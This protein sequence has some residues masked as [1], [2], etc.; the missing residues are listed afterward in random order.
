MWILFQTALLYITRTEMEISQFYS[1]TCTVIKIVAACSNV[2]EE[3]KYQ[4]FILAQDWMETT[5]WQFDVMVCE[6]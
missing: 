4:A 2:V 1:V 3:V 6:V 5:L